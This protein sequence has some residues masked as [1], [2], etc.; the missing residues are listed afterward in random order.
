M[1]EQGRFDPAPLGRR[2]L[3][4]SGRLARAGGAR[5]ASRAVARHR[6]PTLGRRPRLLPVRSAAPP[7]P[8]EYPPASA[9]E[10]P[11][12]Q[13]PAAVPRPG[14]IS[15]EAAKWLFLGELRPNL[16]PMSALKPAPPAVTRKVARSSVPRPRLEEGPSVRSGSAG[17]PL[18]G[19]RPQGERRV[20]AA[21]DVDPVAGTQPD[22]RG[23]AAQPVVDNVTERADD[24]ESGPSRSMA[25]PSPTLARGAVP[26]TAGP[27]PAPPAQPPAVGESTQA[28][29]GSAEKN[30]P[31]SGTDPKSPASAPAPVARSTRPLRRLRPAGPARKLAP[32][33]SSSVPP[34]P[35]QTG[36]AVPKVTAG[37]PTPAVVPSRPAVSVTVTSD[38]AAPPHGDTP[39]DEPAD[40]DAP[41][42]RDVTDGA[43]LSRS[44]A[45][46]REAERPT[47][48]AGRGSASSPASESSTGSARVVAN[49][50]AA[51]PSPGRRSDERVPTPS[52]KLARPPADVPAPATPDGSPVTRAE[53]PAGLSR[54]P[55]E[56]SRAARGSEP[57]TRPTDPSD[58]SRAAAAR[59][60]SEVPSTAVRRSVESAGVAVARVVSRS[61]DAASEAPVD[62]PVQ[63]GS[64]PPDAASP[65]ARPPSLASSAPRT[66]VARATGSDARS[67]A[68]G[69]SESG[70]TRPA[71]AGR[72]AR[73]AVSPGD[74]SGATGTTGAGRESEVASTT[75]RRSVASAG[76]A[77]ARVV[78]RSSD[79]ASEAPGDVPREL[80]ST[81]PDASPQ[82]LASPA[83]R[84]A[85]ARA[86][87]SDARSHASNAS[88]SKPPQPAPAGQRGQ[89]VVRPG[90]TPG[91]ASA[92]GAGRGSEAPSAAVRLSVESRGGTG[93]RVLSR[94]P[95][96]GPV[97]SVDEPSQLGSA[98]PH[99]ARPDSAPPAPPRATATAR[100]N[101]PAK[102]KA[103]DALSPASDPSE[104]E[105]TPR[106]EVAK[107]AP[108]TRSQPGPPQATSARREGAFRLA[109]ARE[110]PRPAGP[111]STDS[112]RA[113]GRAAEP[114]SAVIPAAGGEDAAP[115]PTVPVRLE[116]LTAGPDETVA[117]REH[118]STARQSTLRSQAGE[119]SASPAGI[120]RSA[121]PTD[122]TAPQGPAPAPAPAAAAGDAQWPTA[123]ASSFGP[124][125]PPTAGSPTSATPHLQ[126]GRPTATNRHEAQSPPTARP[127]PRGDV[128]SV[129]PRAVSRPHL[130]KSTRGAGQRLDAMDPPGVSADIPVAALGICNTNA[131]DEPRSVVAPDLGPD[132]TEPPATAG[133]AADAPVTPAA[134]VRGHTVARKRTPVS[135][136]P[137]A[138][139]EPPIGDAPGAAADNIDRLAAGGS[140]VHKSAARGGR[141]RGKAVARNRASVSGSIGGKAN[142]PAS[143][144]RVPAGRPSPSGT[145]ASARVSTPALSREP[146][147]TTSATRIPTAP[148]A[149]SETSAPREGR[150]DTRIPNRENAPV[151]S[152]RRRLTRAV[153]GG[154]TDR[155]SRAAL[156]SFPPL[157]VSRR[158]FPSVESPGGFS[159][160]QGSAGSGDARASRITRIVPGTTRPLVHAHAR[161]TGQSAPGSAVATLALDDP[162]SAPT[163]AREPEAGPPLPNFPLPSARDRPSGQ[164]LARSIGVTRESNGSD[165][166]TV[167]FPQPLD[168]AMRSQTNG[169][170][171]QVARQEIKLES[172]S[173]NGHGA[174]AVP[175]A[176]VQPRPHDAGEFEAL[177]DRVLSRLRRDLIVERERRGDLAGAY[178]R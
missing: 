129:I 22:V 117:R 135:T 27:R 4:R 134:P 72:S 120:A 51:D 93:G 38:E 158:A 5:F 138:G 167:V 43:R 123:N 169:K 3:A 46:G 155:N 177:Y 42:A 6:N 48:P 91:A 12:A 11:V 156:A 105:P 9:P 128:P 99:P 159:A 78:S 56:S 83:P 175:G 87:G 139:P 41:M 125:R 131:I 153:I 130:S 96:P 34:E 137:A 103:A 142:P 13:P 35:R 61:S 73:P 146:A 7:G 67:H 25:L 148:E 106:Q 132:G 28:R 104:T 168:R 140:V 166:S 80:R 90:D 8:S 44:A 63:L 39:T 100:A 33:A 23:D 114:I 162:A 40:Q 52:D 109:P 111:P 165:R 59:R 113:G 127:T 174:D 161:V 150:A 141:L 97:P 54:K 58:A 86:M 133:P 31:A 70:P 98:P 176:E 163:F 37:A 152:P 68:S 122:T 32:K 88:E 154:P 119:A 76:V 118:L 178:F 75:V 136:S 172:A 62:V 55:I 79:A 121:S 69:A 57:V 126:P 49:A 102:T 77:V 81:P 19:S 95:D 107:Q 124:G 101:A 1:T 45:R 171:R 82:S 30:V 94:S 15:E 89:P 53:V 92:T 116:P 112:P 108:A 64:A 24:A 149:T 143:T 21:G 65:D 47:V 66:A 151:R 115:S 18:S 2:I 157:K 36:R 85:I 164:S 20:E 110:R 145:A 74:V 144:S 60:D 29:E 16:L 170:P 14:G 26:T 173:L 84:T 17:T 147:R 10:Q 160:I 71:P 50:Q